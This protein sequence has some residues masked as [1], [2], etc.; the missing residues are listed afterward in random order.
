MSQVNR[1]IYLIKAELEEHSECVDCSSGGWWASLTPST[2][3]K[4]IM[5]FKNALAFILKNGLLATHNP[6]AK[7]LLEALKLLY[8]VSVFLFQFSVGLVSHLQWNQI[9][10][11]S[12]LSI[13]NLFFIYL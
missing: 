4:H 3:M 7:F 5:V 1:D 9:Y 8:K 12:L 10:N 2:L 11:L 6:G 13:K